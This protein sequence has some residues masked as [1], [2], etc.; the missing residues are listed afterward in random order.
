VI[1]SIPGSPTTKEIVMVELKEAPRPKTENGSGAFQTILFAADFSEN[2]TESFR[3]ART[4]AEK[5]KSRLVVFHAAEPNTVAE[6]PGCYGQQVVQ[7]FPIELDKAQHEALKQKMRFVYAAGGHP[8]VDYETGEGDPSREILRI[9]KQVDSD[10]IVMGTH[11]RT[12]LR[13]I[14]AGS[15]A[16]A[17]LRGASCPVMVLRS[18]EQPRPSAEVRTI[19]HPSDFSIDSEAALRVARQLARE[20]EARLV[21]LHVESLDVISY[22][23]PMDEFDPGV[24][25]KDLERLRKRV[26]GPD[27]KYPIAT[28]LRRGSV[29]EGIIDVA[30]EMNCDLIVMGTHGRTGLSRLVMGSVAE[31]VLTRASCPVLMVKAGQHA[32]S[33]S[34]Q[35]LRNLSQPSDSPNF[36]RTRSHTS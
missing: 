14:L 12:G 8:D 34:D 16:V 33:R 23:T 10:L 6:E 4:L 1:G 13:R 3:A 17:V 29:P 30:R 19:V 20:Q 2:S 24:F 15:V 26:E 9:A 35:P 31:D 5:D 27:L 32:A 36:D 25:M 7:F 18:V 28:V 11:G 22:G 21:I